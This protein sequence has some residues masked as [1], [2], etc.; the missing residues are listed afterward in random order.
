VREEVARI[1]LEAAVDNTN[2]SRRSASLLPVLQRVQRKFGYIPPEVVPQIAEFL[3]VPTSRI[4]G[5]ATFYSQFRFSPA[6]RNSI[7]VCRGTACHVRGS[8]RLLDSLSQALGI[9]A[10]ETAEDLS[11]SLDKI[12]CFGSCALA[13]VVLINDKVH[14]RM[15]RAKLLKTVE[16]LRQEMASESEEDEQ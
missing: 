2:K 4:A 14:G 6:A 11:F 13:P 9:R 1:L 8:A 7:T 5:V 15:D 10:G 3:Q 16:K 12:A